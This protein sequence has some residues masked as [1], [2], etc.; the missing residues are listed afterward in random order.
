SVAFDQRTSLVVGRHRAEQDDHHASLAGG[1]GDRAPK[2]G[3][4]IVPR[5]NGAGEFVLFEAQGGRQ[6]AV[7][8]DEV[9]A[10][11]RMTGGRLADPREDDA[12]LEVGGV[13]VLGEDRA[14]RLVVTGVE[15]I[16]R[17]FVLGAERE[18]D[19]AGQGE[20]AS[21]LAMVRDAQGADLD[22]IGG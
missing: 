18:L 9:I 6:I 21:L 11:R 2:G 8:A 12:I 13:E 3:T 15:L 14:G 10:A 16:P 19:V 22:R 20:M 5:T 7:A 1:E 17:L 4:R